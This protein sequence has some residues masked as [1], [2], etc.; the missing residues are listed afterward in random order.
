M[1]RTVNHN[2]GNIKPATAETAQVSIAPQM[3][4]MLENVEYRLGNRD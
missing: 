4:L 3:V 2:R 1:R